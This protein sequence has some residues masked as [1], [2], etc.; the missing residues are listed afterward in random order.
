MLF[1]ICSRG[2]GQEVGQGKIEGGDYIRMDDVWWCALLSSH[3][4]L[5]LLSW[6]SPLPP[7]CPISASSGLPHHGLSTEAF[8]FLSK[9]HGI[10]LS[11]Q[12][13]L[14][15]NGVAQVH[16]TRGQVM[17]KENRGSVQ[18]EVQHVRR[19]CYE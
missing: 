17:R 14:R 5:L 18:K 2:R 9:R 6:P 1:F 3:L 19:F 13:A 7:P 15:G 11:S 8:L 16:R 10:S 12:P 4:A